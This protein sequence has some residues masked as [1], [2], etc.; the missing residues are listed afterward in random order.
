M[1]ENVLVESAGRFKTQSKFWTLGTFALNAGVLAVMIF[2]PLLHPEALPKT[3]LTTMLMAPAPPPPPAMPVAA[4]AA[5]PQ[6]SHTAAFTAPPRISTHIT[7]DSG[8]PSIPP[9]GV[10]TTGP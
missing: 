7:E 1:F 2:L 9:I 10:M 3:A 6:Q 5:A 8:P 4:R